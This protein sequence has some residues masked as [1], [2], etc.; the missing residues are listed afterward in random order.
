MKKGGKILLK[1]QSS[2]KEKQFLVEGHLIFP[3]TTSKFTI[4]KYF[5]RDRIRDSV[6]F[7][8]NLHTSL[9]NARGELIYFKE[10]VFPGHIR[11]RI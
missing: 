9:S 11:M 3:R 8:K 2:P 7:P 1:G 4:L 10:V 6:K 5:K